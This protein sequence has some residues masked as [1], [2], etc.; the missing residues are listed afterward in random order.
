MSKIHAPRNANT[1][2]S[3][4]ASSEYI[5]DGIALLFSLIKM[6]GHGRALAQ[7]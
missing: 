7:Y 1:V 5:H 3:N 2:T 4:V 6:R